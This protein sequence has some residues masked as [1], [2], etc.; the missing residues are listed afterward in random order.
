MPCHELIVP[1]YISYIDALSREFDTLNQ[2][3]GRYS[4]S[5]DQ[6]LRALTCYTS[7]STAYNRLSRTTGHWFTAKLGITGTGRSLSRYPSELRDLICLGSQQYCPRLPRTC[8]LD[9][10][11]G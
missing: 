6:M 8:I 2:S 5:F 11:R 1:I 4:W 9:Q 3:L 10:S 7:F